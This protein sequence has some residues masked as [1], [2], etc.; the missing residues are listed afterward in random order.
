MIPYTARDAE[1]H[2]N[3]TLFFEISFI[4]VFFTTIRAA[5]LLAAFTPRFLSPR[6]YIFSDC[7]TL[8]SGGAATRRIRKN[9][10]PDDGT[11]VLGTDP[12]CQLLLACIPIPV[13]LSSRKL[14]GSI[15]QNPR[16][17]SRISSSPHEFCF[18]FRVSL[19]AKSALRNS[20][21]TASGSYVDNKNF[22]SYQRGGS[23]AFELQP[24]IR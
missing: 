23:E 15:W 18:N 6:L 20:C 10:V 21:K 4:R 13:V 11:P 7:A 24:G 5:L 3:L 9:D 16:G 19:R 14:R 17:D 12:Y 22:N 8:S 2:R 1:L